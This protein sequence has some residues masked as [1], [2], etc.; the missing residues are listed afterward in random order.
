MSGMVRGVIGGM[1]AKSRFATAGLAAATGLSLLVGTACAIGMLSSADA[2]EGNSLN[3]STFGGAYKISQEKAFFEPFTKMTGMAISVKEQVNPLELLK[4]WKSASAAGA[5]VIDLSAYQAEKACDEGYLSPLNETHI[6]K[7]SN[8][9]PIAKD[10]IADSLMDCAVPSVAWSAL[11]VVNNGKFTKNKPRTWADFFN[12]K[13]FPGKRSLKKSARHSLEMALMASGVQPADIYFTLSTIEG[14]KRAFDNL[15]N[16]KD[17]IVWWDNSAAA[18]SNLKT[19]DVVMGLA[20]NGRLFNA[21]IGDGLDVTLVWQEQIY[22]LDYWG[23][24]VNS[25]KQEKA[26]EFVKFATEPKQLAEQSKWMPYGPM[27][28]SSLEFVNT[29]SIAGVHMAPYLTTTKAHFHKALKFNE[30][31]WNSEK[32]KEAEAR[33]QQWLTGEISWPEPVAKVK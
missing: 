23:V 29:H 7:S 22:D 10:F 5:D 13:K 28:A 20:Y 21:I 9:E 17:H 1:F 24:P 15:D 3:I 31:W 11:M 19:E 12:V 27:R 26:L 16:L 14:Q 8:D 32:G 2:A 25:T 33:F 30:G 6:A 18:I 4:E